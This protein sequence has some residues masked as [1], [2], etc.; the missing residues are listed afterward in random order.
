MAYAKRTMKPR[1][2][3]SVM[4]LRAV[5]DRHAPPRNDREPELPPMNPSDR[6]QDL[7]LDGRDMRFEGYSIKTLEHGGEYP[8]TMPQVIEITDAAGHKAAYVPL[9]RNGKVIQ[10]ARVLDALKRCGAIEHVR[11]REKP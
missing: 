3:M 8:D 7:Y 4:K 1:Y 9:S 2:S 11:C 10:S 6:P 5:L